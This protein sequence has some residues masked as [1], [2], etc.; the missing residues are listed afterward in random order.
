M[1]SCIFGVIEEKARFG[2]RGT[3]N[4]FFLLERLC[5]YSHAAF[6]RT[7]FV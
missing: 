3:V 7:E 5:R 2:P 4:D 1:Y 6:I